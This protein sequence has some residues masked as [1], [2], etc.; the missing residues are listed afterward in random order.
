MF[1]TY[2][3]FH[4]NIL[5]PKLVKLRNRM[6]KTHSS[7]LFKLSKTFADSTVDVG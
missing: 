6:A 3:L 4:F 5:A 7:V 2:S 1:L